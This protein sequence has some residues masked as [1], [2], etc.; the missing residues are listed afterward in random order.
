MGE[1]GE[2]GGVGDGQEAG[3]DRL[4]AEFVQVEGDGVGAGE[5]GEGG[6]V[7]VAEEQRPAVGGVDVEAGAVVVGEVGEG[8]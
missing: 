3:R 4:P 6:L 5:A 2:G 1:G 8:R 7:G